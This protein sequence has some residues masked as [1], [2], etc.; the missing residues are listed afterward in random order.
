MHPPLYHGQI[1]ANFKIWAERFEILVHP[2]FSR[3]HHAVYIGLRDNILDFGQ[4]RPLFYFHKNDDIF[5]PRNNIDLA[6]GNFETLRED[7]PAP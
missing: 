4:R 3:L 1:K 5:P 7:F 6:F 2:D